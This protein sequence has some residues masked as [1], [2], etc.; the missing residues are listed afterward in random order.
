MKQYMVDELRP[1]DHEL[2]KE[3]LDEHLAYAGLDGLYW[4]PIDSTL[5]TD[6]QAAH[7]ECA[8][9]YIALVLTP[10]SLTCELLVRTR[11]RIRCDCIAYATPEQRD[12]IVDWVD[13][14]FNELGIIA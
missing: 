7:S 14:I 12:W 11:N 1:G 2:L 5:L 9:F 8:P 4:K 3:Y 13:N 10:E 6:S